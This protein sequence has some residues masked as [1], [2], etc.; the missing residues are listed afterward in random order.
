V[1]AFILDSSVYI[2]YLN[3]LDTL[4]TKTKNFI[5]SITSPDIDF[6]VP[7]IVFL[8]VGNVLQKI[9]PQFRNDDLLRFFED[10]TIINL[11]IELAQQMLTI[12][13]HFNLK[14]S[15]AIIVAC[16]KMENA[17]LVTWD[18]KLLKEAKKVADT[19]TPKTFL[20][21]ALLKR[22]P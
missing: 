7:I 18:E 16:S 22:N 15:D 14:T 6:I 10:H 17:T 2:S 13:K 9:L 11:D 21:K 5:N 20:S 1:K 8:E 4:H 19:Q 12:F 3:P